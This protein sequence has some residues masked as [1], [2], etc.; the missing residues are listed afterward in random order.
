MR[1]RG[2]HAARS[3]ARPV[4]IVK[5]GGRLKVNRLQSSSKS[6]EATFVKGQSE[7]DPI[8]Y[9]GEGDNGESLHTSSAT[10]S[11]CNDASDARLAFEASP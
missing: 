6:D 10:P 3:E 8:T 2:V 9:I 11:N 4:K 7:T 5:P 1:A